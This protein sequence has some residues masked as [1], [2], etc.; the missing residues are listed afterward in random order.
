MARFSIQE[1]A[2]LLSGPL[3]SRMIRHIAV[4]DPTGADLDPDK[5]V[6]GLKRRRHRSEEVAGDDGT[7]MIVKECRPTLNGWLPRTSPCFR[8]L[9]MVSRIDEQAQFER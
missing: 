9:P 2:E 7:C 6:Q 3:G 1:F 4:Q 8:Y 5:D